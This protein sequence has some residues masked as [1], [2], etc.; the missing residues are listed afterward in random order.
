MY[1]FSEKFLDKSMIRREESL[2]FTFSILEGGN[3]IF[4]RISFARMG[5]GSL[6][7]SLLQK[8][9]LPVPGRPISAMNGVLPGVGASN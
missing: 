1:F 7:V 3:R 4:R 6:S 2:V 5:K 9:G 8:K